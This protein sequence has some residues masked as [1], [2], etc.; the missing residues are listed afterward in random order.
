MGRLTV[1]KGARTRE[2]AM[3]LLAFAARPDHQAH[4]AAMIASGPTNVRA[5]DLINPDRARERNW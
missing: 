5:Y 3:K 2:N 1:P 4:F